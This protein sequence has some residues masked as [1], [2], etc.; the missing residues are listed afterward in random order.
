[1]VINKEDMVSGND[2]YHAFY[3][4]LKKKAY[5]TK[6]AKA[7]NL[8]ENIKDQC[9]DLSP[10]LDVIKKSIVCIRTDYTFLLPKD[11]IDTKKG[12]IRRSWDCSNL[13]KVIEDGIFSSLKGLDDSQVTYKVEQK[14]PSS[15]KEIVLIDI[16]MEFYG[17]T[18][19]AKNLN[20]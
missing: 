11:V 2:L 4:K 6:T 5:I 17:E 16:I 15:L 14:A 19:S 18:P 1:M 7:R 10:L 13:V 20:K 12:G 8:Q 3:A 9:K